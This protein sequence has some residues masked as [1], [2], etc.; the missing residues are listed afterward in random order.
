MQARHGGRSVEGSEDRSHDR[1]LYNQRLMPGDDLSGDCRRS[2]RVV[3]LEV[4]GEE[5]KAVQPCYSW[6]TTKWSSL[7]S[8]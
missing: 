7:A 4:I 6:Q 8:R 2:G 3:L 5:F 1:L